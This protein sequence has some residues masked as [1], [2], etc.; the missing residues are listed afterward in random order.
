M[1]EII[2][3]ECGVLFESSVQSNVIEGKYYLT[4]RMKDSCGVGSDGKE[5]MKKVS[6][7]SCPCCKK[8]ITEE[9]E[10]VDK[11]LIK[12]GKVDSSSL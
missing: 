4:K 9:G 3:P 2:C 7:Y 5:L 10:K 12:R 6:I 8:W 1:A 11:K